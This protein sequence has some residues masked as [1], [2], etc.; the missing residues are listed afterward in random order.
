MAGVERLKAKDPLGY[1][2]EKLARFLAIVVKLV[3]G[4]IPS[5]PGSDRYLQGNTLGSGYAH[6]RRAKFGNGRYRLFFRYSTGQR[7]I[8]YVWLNDEN[9]LRKRGARSDP[10]TVFRA[11]LERGKPPTDWDALERECKVWEGD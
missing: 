1:K 11:M 4:D 10:Y 5:N 3:R 8:A 7:M 6:W 9:T 2:D